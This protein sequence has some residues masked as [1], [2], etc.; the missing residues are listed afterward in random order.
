MSSIKHKKTAQSPRDSIQDLLR[1][2]Q[3]YKPAHGEFSYAERERAVTEAQ[4]LFKEASWLARQFPVNEDLP[5]A[6]ATAQQ[7]WYA[8][9]EAAYPDG[10]WED[11]R[12]R[13]T[14]DAA[15]LESVVS[16]LEAD[17]YFFRSGYTKAWLIRGIKPPMLTPAYQKRLQQVVLALV[18]KRDDRDFRAFCKLA[19]KVDDAGFRE[20][21]RQRADEGNFDVR[22]RAWWVLDALAQKD[23]MAQGRKKAEESPQ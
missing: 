20:Q 8:A 4:R 12:K 13:R 16:F 7:L 10:F 17:P 19:R 23:Q 15:S 11:V 6:S 5:R 18:D 2:I 14:G 21:L 1:Q 3:E 22:R 9:M